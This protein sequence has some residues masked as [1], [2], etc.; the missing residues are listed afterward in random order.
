MTI[1]ILADHFNKV[2]VEAMNGGDEF[3][4]ESAMFIGR[5]LVCQMVEEKLITDNYAAVVAQKE[6][7]NE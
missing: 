6:N 3:S 5:Q 4:V 2:Y 1:Q 7:P